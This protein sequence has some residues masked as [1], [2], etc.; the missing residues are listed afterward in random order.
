MI[1]TVRRVARRMALG[2]AVAGLGL[3]FGASAQGAT[4]DWVL[5]DRTQVR[6]LY[7]DGEL[8]DGDGRRWAVGIVPG[9]R[10]TAQGA[11]AG[12]R[13]A[14]D[15]FVEGGQALAR[16]VDGDF[17]RARG[18]QIEDGVDFAGDALEIAV[19]GI[20]DGL[21]E[22]RDDVAALVGEQPFAWAPRALWRFTTGVV[23]EPPVRLV[24]SGA[25]AASGLG[26]AVIAPV[27]G[28]TVPVLEASGHAAVGV[29][30]DGA[31]RGVAVPAA[32]LVWHQ[33]AFALAVLGPEP[34]PAQDGRFG[35]RILASGPAPAT[36]PAGTDESGNRKELAGH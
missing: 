19:P 8:T 16:Y 27:V 30:V 28:T 26:Y 15:R 29:L 9:V 21:A 25:G 18:G 35:L 5:A 13:D 3:G 36:S 2:F 10:R 4:D 23:F 32:K 22:T 11:R 34:T 1:R 6:D 12:F 20:P 14:G 31:I 33:P 7:L 17:W 24:V